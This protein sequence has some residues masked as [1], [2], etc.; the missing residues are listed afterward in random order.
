LNTNYNWYK[1]N[2]VGLFCVGDVLVRL[3]FCYWYNVIVVLRVQLLHWTRVAVYG[4]RGCMIGVCT[5]L[6]IYECTS[7]FFFPGDH[8]PT[9]NF[10]VTWKPI[11][12][13][14]SW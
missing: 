6:D 7:V 12:S 10:T 11:P 13:T 9:W 8:C 14:Y 5:S 2:D 1:V 4:V 3:Y